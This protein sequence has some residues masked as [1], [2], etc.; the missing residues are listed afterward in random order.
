[1]NNDVNVVLFHDKNNSL[2]VCIS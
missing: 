2:P 1:M